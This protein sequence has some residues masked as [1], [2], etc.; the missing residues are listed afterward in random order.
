MKQAAKSPRP[1]RQSRPGEDLQAAEDRTLFRHAAR[2]LRQ[3]AMTDEAHRH[4]GESDRLLRIASDVSRRAA[5]A[6]A[7]KDR[8]NRAYDVAACINAARLVPGDAESAQRSALLAEAA[9][10]LAR[11]SDIPP[12]AIVFP[13]PALSALWARMEGEEDSGGGQ[14]PHAW[15]ALAREAQHEALQLARALLHLGAGEAGQ[16]PAVVHGMVARMAQL[17][18]ITYLAAALHGERHDRRGMPDLDVLRELF[19]GGWGPLA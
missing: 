19:E 15:R 6:P 11:I 2:L 16:E 8:H 7:C 10:Q 13:R 12:E 1:R 17:M 3:A 5:R 9:G 14:L 4:S 18:E